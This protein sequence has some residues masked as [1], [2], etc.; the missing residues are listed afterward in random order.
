MAQAILPA[1][2]DYFLRVR[3]GPNHQQLI[4][5]CVNDETNPIII[6]N[7]HFSGY[8]IVRMVDFKGVTPQMDNSKGNT[9][10]AKVN[11]SGQILNQPQSSY[12]KGKNRH[13]S[14]VLQGRFKK[15]WHG[16]EIIFGVD[17]D[18]PVRAPMGTATGIKIAKWLDPSIEADVECSK[19]YIFSPLVSAMSSLSVYDANSPDLKKPAP[20]ANSSAVTIVSSVDP[21]Q[22]PESFESK[23]G[24]FSFHS[25]VVEENLALLMVDDKDKDKKATSHEKRKKHFT[26]NANRVAALIKPDLVYS[27]DFYDSHFD[28]NSCMIKLPGFSLNAFKYWDGQ[29]I[30]YSATTRDRSAVFFVVQFELVP[31]KNYA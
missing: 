5:V 19:P 28:F 25:S 13:Y 16:D 6:D 26:S 29:P 12:F 23:L 18:V 14:M 8:L 15:Q 9:N 22:T 3:A 10:T 21:K 30:R 7:E 27:M 24:Q 1:V 4:T 17:L 2:E 11:G 31:K 20:N